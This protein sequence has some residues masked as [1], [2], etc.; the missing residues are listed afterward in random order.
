MGEERGKK[1]I[2]EILTK[3]GN[4]DAANVKIS[5][6]GYKEF[7]IEQLGDTDT[8]EAITAG[9][10]LMNRQEDTCQWHI[11]LDVLDQEYLDYIKS[12]HGDNYAEWTTSVFAR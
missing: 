8:A 10:K 2:E 4:G 3:L 1:E 6:D 11:M 7:M 9:L 5:Y 12:T